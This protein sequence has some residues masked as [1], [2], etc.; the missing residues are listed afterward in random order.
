[1]KELKCPKC[2]H[3]FHVDQEIFESLANQVK[4]IVFKEEVERRLQELRAHIEAEMDVRR[5]RDEQKFKEQISRHEH[6]LS[7]R[8][9]EVASLKERLENEKRSQESDFQSRM[10]K[11]ET[12]HTQAIAAKDKEIASLQS[13]IAQNDSI[14]RVAILEEQKKVAATIQQKDT[15][16]AEL[17]NRVEAEIKESTIRENSIREQHAVIL[18]QKDETIEYYKDMKTRMSTKMIGETLEIHC[19]NLFLQAQSMGMFPDAYFGK[20]NDISTGTKGDFIFRDYIDGQ[21]YISVMFEMKNEADTTATK[22]KNTD[23]LDKLN[24]DRCDKE[25]EYA[26]L[27]SLLE[28]D[29]DFY[30][31]GIVN[32]SH[33][34]PKM[35]VIRPQMFMTIITLLSQASRKSHDELRQLRKELAIAKAQT[36]DVTNF[37]RRRDQFVLSFSKLVE[38][39][40]KKHNDAIGGIDKVIEALEKQ[41]ESLRKVKNLFEVSEQKLI[42]ANETAEN[43]F[44]IKKLSHGNPTMRAKFEEARRNTDSE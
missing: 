15:E 7:E 30:N 11:R 20:D 4:T 25:C 19:Q 43:D 10:L 6:W 38:A 9:A 21:Q 13:A 37:E 36:V 32:M 42:R 16:I 23:F 26:V 31:D 18:R 35:Y 12:E 44:T 34:Y 29:N 39:H 17:R 22:H 40:S 1:M 3:V 14:R 2:A 41:V 27:V 24:K 28:R 8:D 5:L 33:K